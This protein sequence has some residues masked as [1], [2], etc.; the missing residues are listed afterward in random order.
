MTAAIENEGLSS[1]VEDLESELESLGRRVDVLE[2]TMADMVAIGRDFWRGEAAELLLGASTTSWSY[3]VRRDNLPLSDVTH[4]DV[5]EGVYAKRWVGREG[6][7]AA[8]IYIN[9]TTPL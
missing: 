1:L 8:T 9:R 2:R 5:F 4:F 3:D 6:E 7:I